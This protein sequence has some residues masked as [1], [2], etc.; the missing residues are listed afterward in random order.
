VARAG[1]AAYRAAVAMQIQDHD[2]LPKFDHQVLPP[3]SRRSLGDSARPPTIPG[4]PGMVGSHEN[5]GNFKCHK[6][7]ELL[8]HSHLLFDGQRLGREVPML[9]GVAVAPRSAAAGA[10]LPVW[11]QTNHHRR[12]PGASGRKAPYAECP[13]CLFPNR[14]TKTGQVRGFV[15]EPNAF[16]S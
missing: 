10:H 9:Q 13:V 4:M 6:W 16:V 11:G 14:R 3:A 15:R 12:P 5:W 2:K 7:G 8:R 1:R